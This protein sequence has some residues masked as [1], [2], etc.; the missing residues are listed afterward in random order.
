M[1]GYDI[2]GDIHG[3]A[4]ALERL[5]DK[6]GY[7]TDGERKPSDRKIIFLG[8]FIDRGSENKRVVTL[9]RNLIKKG[10]AEAVM[11]NH[12]YNAICYYTKDPEGKYLREHSDK[13]KTQHQTFLD[14]YEGTDELEETIEWFKTLPLFIEK[15]GIR[16]VHACWDQ[17][18]I[19][20]LRKELGPAHLLDAK[21]LRA[22]SIKDS[23]EYNAIEKILKGPEHPLP[24]GFS[25][26]DKDG[27]DRKDVRIKWWKS[28]AENLR[29][30]SSVDKDHLDKIP[31]EP[32]Q[33]D[34][35]YPKD[36][37]PVFFG[38]YWMRYGGETVQQNSA[39]LRV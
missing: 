27:H 28:D 33:L 13:N 20:D 30:V 17:A 5:L 38:H 6:L 12:E 11:G 21:F 10:I 14:E 19:D 35:I 7:S 15:D 9:V 26:K 1:T 18:V 32:L 16:L 4:T 34:C 24:E 31:E 23:P 8:D 25:F 29:E 3:H 22:S 37:T 36:A 2:I 39:C